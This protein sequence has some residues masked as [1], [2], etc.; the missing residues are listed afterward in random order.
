MAGN[1]ANE[2]LRAGAVSGQVTAPLQCQAG[3]VN[4]SYGT[5]TRDW[6]KRAQ[7]AESV[8]AARV[9][10]GW[11]SLL[12]AASAAVATRSLGRREQETIRVSSN[13]FP[14]LPSG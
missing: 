10:A 3:T 4:F 11:R 6:W 8:L 12:Q 5:G 1:A 7:F 9:I 14:S 2:H 13:P